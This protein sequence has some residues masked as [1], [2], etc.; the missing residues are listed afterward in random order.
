MIELEDDL[1]IEEPL[2]DDL[3]RES[4][5]KKYFVIWQNKGFLLL[6]IFSMLSSIGEWL[7]FIAVLYFL[8]DK[9]CH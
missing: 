1:L 7:T 8:N 3:I 4:S 9:A 6:N 5:W 2:Q